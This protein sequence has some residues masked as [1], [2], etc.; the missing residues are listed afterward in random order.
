MKS[1]IAVDHGGFPLKGHLAK[2]IQDCG[3]MVVDLGSHSTDTVDYPDYGRSRHISAYIQGREASGF[4]PD[5]TDWR[6]ARSIFVADDE[7]TAFSYAMTESG[8]HDFYFFNVMTKLA[9]SPAP[10]TKHETSP[11]P[12]TGMTGLLRQ[13]VIAGTVDQVV[14]QILHLRYTVGAF[15]TLLYTGHDWMDAPLA[16]RSMELMAREVMPRVNAALQR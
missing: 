16:R 9:G 13:R 6:V 3:H 12:T 1:A 5:A 15:G 10:S 4:S 7:A 2:V 11:P 8:P 14:E